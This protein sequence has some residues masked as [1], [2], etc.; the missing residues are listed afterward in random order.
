M[1]PAIQRFSQ[2]P[3][4][5]KKATQKAPKRLEKSSIKGSK[6]V[7]IFGCKIGSRSIFAKTPGIHAFQ[8]LTQKTDRSLGSWPKEPQILMIS[9]FQGWPFFPLTLIL[10]L[11]N[12]LQAELNLHLTLIWPSILINQS[13]EPLLYLHVSWFHPA[14][15]WPSS[16]AYCCWKS[17]YPVPF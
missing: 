10:T 7:R 4:L 3:F 11:T 16:K 15:L 17:F 6:R 8:A 9:A 13:P 12:I 14:S 1:G 2:V 5:C